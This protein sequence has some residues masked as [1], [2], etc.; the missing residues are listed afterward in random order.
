[1]KCEAIQDLLLDYV[2]RELDDARVAEV[3]EHL[4]TCADCRRA[5]AEIRATLKLLHSAARRA[6]DLPERLS[7]ERRARVRW[8]FMHPLLDWIYRN[9]A[10]VTAF[11]TV[12]VVAL[13]LRKIFRIEVENAPLPSGVTV[14]IGT[15]APETNR[16]GV[17]PPS[18][19][20]ETPHDH[21]TNAPTPQN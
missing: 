4:E 18:P 16:A 17:R 19:R 6:G 14:T 12:V 15:G 9:H 3:R 13:L 5:A 21:E 10:L 7:D 20:P 11:I 2:T 1:M 8:A